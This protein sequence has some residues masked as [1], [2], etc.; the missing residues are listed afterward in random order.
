MEGRA[1][2]C[3]LN[4]VWPP[5]KREQG[6]YASV[7]IQ[8]DYN[9]CDHIVTTFYS[10]SRCT[11]SQ[12]ECRIC[13]MSSAGTRT[14]LRRADACRRVAAQV[15]LTRSH[16][17]TEVIESFLTS[18]ACRA[19]RL[20]E[21]SDPDLGQSAGIVES[22]LQLGPDNTIIAGDLNFSEESLGKRGTLATPENVDDSSEN[23]VHATCEVFDSNAIEFSRSK[24]CMEDL[25]REPCDP[26]HL[27]GLQP[28][29]RLPDFSVWLPLCHT[30]PAIARLSM[31]RRQSPRRESRLT[32]SPD[33]WCGRP[34]ASGDTREQ[35]CRHADFSRSRGGSRPGVFEDRSSSKFPRPPRRAKCQEAATQQ[36]LP[37]Q[38]LGL[39]RFQGYNDNAFAAHFESASARLHLQACHHCRRRHH[40]RSVAKRERAR[41]GAE[42]AETTVPDPAGRRRHR[43]DAPA[44][45]DS[46]SYVRVL[47]GLGHPIPSWRW[48][49]LERLKTLQVKWQF[50]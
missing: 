13:D 12:V 8:A 32:V 50:L 20:C 15:D 39:G 23:R 34:T 22:H 40:R 19:R 45:A 33:G 14:V 36:R 46:A 42:T 16:V 27:L 48:C 31:H 21:E 26:G 11:S 18:A 38:Y 10:V 35:S 17:V 3:D 29:P 1:F 43:R 7:N 49:V 6:Q 4:I 44:A 28:L 47:P 5:P 41:C 25:Q 9:T 24:V 30:L 37:V 2:E